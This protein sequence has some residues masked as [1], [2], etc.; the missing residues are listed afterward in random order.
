M[1]VNES[2]TFLSRAQVIA[3][4]KKI[5]IDLASYKFT[6]LRIEG[7]SRTWEKVEI[8]KSKTFALPDPAKEQKIAQKCAGI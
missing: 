5:E 6:K 8:L 3:G 1:P 2:R 7:Q 4:R